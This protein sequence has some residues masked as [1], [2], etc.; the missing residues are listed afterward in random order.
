[1]SN[2]IQEENGKQ[3]FTFKGSYYSYF[4]TRRFVIRFSQR[5]GVETYLP[6]AKTSCCIAK[7]YGESSVIFDYLIF[8]K[9]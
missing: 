8:E 9:Y 6:A 1:M 7:I 4:N 3:N 2:A 5:A